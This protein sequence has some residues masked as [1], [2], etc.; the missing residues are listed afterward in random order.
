M[1]NGCQT[2]HVLFENKGALTSDMF[3]TLK[4]IQTSDLD[5][6]GKVITTT[7]SQSTVTKEAFAT[8]RPYH[9]T[10]EDFFTAMRAQGY[11][12]YYERRPH[13]FDD[14]EDIRETLIVSAP[15]LIKSFVS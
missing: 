8:I 6:T 15:V 14:R 7:N 11:D 1:V 10:I 9:R 13:Q 5:L 2:S 12:Y 4:L 3:I